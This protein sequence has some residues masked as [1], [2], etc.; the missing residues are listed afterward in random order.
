[1]SGR[2][3]QVLGTDLISVEQRSG[4]QSNASVIVHVSEKDIIKLMVG[5]LEEWERW[6]VTDIWNKQ[7]AI[8]EGGKEWIDV[9]ELES[10][11]EL[12]GHLNYVIDFFG[13]EEQKIPEE[14]SGTP[15][16]NSC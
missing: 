14:A 16:C 15:S 3:I 2:L 1:M 6:A 7:L 5:E 13:G 12:L 4:E 9:R 10:D 11:T 8:K